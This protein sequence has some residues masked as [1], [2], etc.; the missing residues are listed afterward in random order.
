A[1]VV[2]EQGGDAALEAVELRPGVLAQGEDEVDV[3]VGLVDQ[4]RELDRE[5]AVAVLAFVVEEVLLELVEHDEQR[6]HPLGP[7]VDGAGAGA[8]SSS[9]PSRATYSL[10]GA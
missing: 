6:A 2:R 8:A 10:S 4:A 1:D 9:A 5:G 7:A 3:Q